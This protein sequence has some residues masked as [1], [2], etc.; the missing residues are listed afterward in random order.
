TGRS[1]LTCPSRSRP[2]PRRSTSSATSR[3]LLHRVRF[4]PT[5]RASE[6]SCTAIQLVGGRIRSDMQTFDGRMARRHCSGMKQTDFQAAR[7]T[8]RLGAVVSNFRV[9]Q[10]L[11]GPAAVAAV[12]KADA[13]GLGAKHVSEALSRA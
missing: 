3:K 8:V 5:C 10:R 12:V 13:Y 4:C 9:C 2:N 11:A 1:C 6:K 7:L